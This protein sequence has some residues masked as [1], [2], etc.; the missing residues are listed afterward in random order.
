MKHRIRVAGI[1]H[2]NN[3]LLLVE[4]MSPIGFNRWSP[5]GGGLE[6]Q[7]ADI[8][9]G[10]A[11]E[12]YEETGVSVRPGALR[13][14]SEFLHHYSNTL[15]LELWIDCHPLEG[16]VFGAPHLNNLQASDG[17]NSVK[18]WSYD[19]LQTQRVNRPLA[20]QSFWDNLTG[21]V[22]A[23]QYLGRWEE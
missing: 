5:P 2:Q 12:V 20:K 10:V 3:Q 4:Q 15:M 23:V 13:F 18:W 7:D 11:R 8:F 21:P 19:S 1:L 14:V 9:N 22:Q 17:I 6:A 16:D